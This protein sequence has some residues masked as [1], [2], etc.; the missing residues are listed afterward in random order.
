MKPFQV[1]LAK[2]VTASFSGEEV[3]LPI[4]IKAKIDNYWNELI[5]SGKSYTRGEVFTVTHKEVSEDGIDVLVEKTDYA[6]YLYCQNVEALGEYGVHIIHTACLVETKDEEFLFGEMG[7][8]TARSGIYQ[9]CGGGIDNSD[10]NGSQFDFLHNITK[11]LKEELDIDVTNVDRVGSFREAYFKEGGPTDKMTVIFK[12]ILNE[13]TEEFFKQYEEFVTR[14]RNEGEEPEFGRII[15]LKKDEQEIKKF[16]SQPD[17]KL[18]EYMQPLF[19]KI[20]LDI[21]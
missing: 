2:K 18:D 20:A 8:Q 3:K 14:L 16:L 13:T 21:N 9:L 6:H 4:E 11:E 1:S 19:E 17:L 12:V 7:P 15:A 5:A 10:L